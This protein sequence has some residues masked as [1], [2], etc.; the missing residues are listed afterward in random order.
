MSVNRVTLIGNLGANP[1]LKYLTSGQAVCEMRVATNEQW[2]DKS[3]QKQEKVEW[4]RIVAWGKIGESCA[5][6]LAKGRQVYVEGKITTRSWDDKK[7]GEKRYM[8]EIIANTV[9]FLGSKSERSTRNE[10]PSSEPI[11]PPF[12]DIPSGVDT[13]VP[14]TQKDIPF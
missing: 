14:T 6:Y 1:E 13:E 12:D 7:T 5:K 8:T 4:H 2:V 3:G 10:I 9:Q 11:D